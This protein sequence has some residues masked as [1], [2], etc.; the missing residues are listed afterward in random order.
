MLQNFNISQT[1][2]VSIMK[3][4]LDRQGLQISEILMQTEQEACN[5]ERGLFKILNRNLSCSI[6]RL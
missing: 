4:W 1:E 2:R 3:N 5:D 6:M